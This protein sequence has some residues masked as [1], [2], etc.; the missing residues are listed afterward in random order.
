MGLYKLCGHKGRV[1]DRCQHAWWGSFKHKGRLYRE[2]LARWGNCTVDS[3]AQAGAV[4]DRMRD[5]IRTDTFSVGGVTSGG[6]LTFARFAEDYIARYVDAKQLRSAGTIKYRIA[7]LVRQ[8]GTMTLPDIQT[9]HIEEYLAGL[10]QPQLLSKHHQDPRVRRPATINRHLSLLRHMFNWAVGRGYLQ[11]TPF[12]RGN[13]ALIKQEREDN[14]RHRRVAPDEERRLLEVAPDRLRPLI[15]IALDTGLRRGE[16][17]ALRW[18]DVNT[19]PG[20]LRLRGETT[21]SGKTRWVPVATERLKAVLEYLRFDAAGEEKGPDVAVCSTETGEPIGEF[22]TAWMTTV[23]RAHDVT[24]TWVEGRDSGLLTEEC[25]QAFQRIGLRWHDLRHEYA[26]R[27]VERGV[28]LSQVRDLLGHASI[29]TT[30]R[31]DNQKPEALFEAA[32]R[33]ETGESFKFVSRSDVEPAS[34][35]TPAFDASDAKLL[36]ELEREVGVGN[37]VRTRDFRSHSPALFR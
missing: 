13:Q 6:P 9:S 31:Y 14:R 29:T 23:L 28:P 10:K 21:K 35:D 37:G 11:Q 19:R 15:T 16:M 7:P 3:K 22:R 8:F 17:L 5:A 20:W 24:P 26:S 32:S 30:E 4:L 2:S 34:A 36:K 12:Q 33:L 25:R 18:A 27:L 1:R